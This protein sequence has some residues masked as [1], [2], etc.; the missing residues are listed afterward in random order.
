MSCPEF[1]SDI[2]ILPL[3]CG[4]FHLIFPLLSHSALDSRH[5]EFIPSPSSALLSA[6]C[7]HVALALPLS[8]SASCCGSLSLTLQPFCSSAWRELAPSAPGTAFPAYFHSVKREWP[9]CTEGLHCR[10][11]PSP[12]P[13]TLWNVFSSVCR[14]LETTVTWREGKFYCLCSSALVLLSGSPLP[15]SAL[16]PCLGDMTALTRVP[17]TVAAIIRFSPSLRSVSP[18]D[19]YNQLFLFLLYLVCCNRSCLW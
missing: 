17:D 13:F 1:L 3:W 18:L 12:E 5:P 6:S 7:Q 14:S 16:C 15:S 19:S 9:P 11:F 10:F 2:C 4:D 8:G